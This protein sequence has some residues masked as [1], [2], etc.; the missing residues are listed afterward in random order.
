MLLSCD[1]HLFQV[2]KAF[3]EELHFHGLLKVADIDKLFANL[4]ELCEVGDTS[5]ATVCTL[6]VS[7]HV[8]ECTA[9]ISM[10][11]CS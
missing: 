4:S 7:V 5:V 10:N 11:M 6:C 3:L 2:Y 1:W 9:P 8:S